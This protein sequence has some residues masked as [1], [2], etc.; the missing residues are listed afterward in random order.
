MASAIG[1][2]RKWFQGDKPTSWDHYDISLSKK[3]EAIRLG[4]RLTDKYAPLEYTKR[5][6]LAAELAGEC[7]PTEIAYLL[8][9]LVRIYELRR[10]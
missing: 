7:D 1:I 6:D 10:D 3:A 9:W 8:G 5:Q 2:A 4:A